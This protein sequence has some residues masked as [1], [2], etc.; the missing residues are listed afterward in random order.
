M[1]LNP[2]DVLRHKETRTVKTHSANNIF[3]EAEMFAI[4]IGYDPQI[5]A[6]RAER[7][8]ESE[9]PKIDSNKKRIVIGVHWE[10]NWEKV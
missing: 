10:V 6:Y 5:N 1:R 4:I 2:M 3:A 9:H 7:Y 8:Y